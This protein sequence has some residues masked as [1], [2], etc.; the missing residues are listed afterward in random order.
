MLNGHQGAEITKSVL[1]SRRLLGETGVVFALLACENET[2]RVI[3][4]PDIITRGIANES[5]EAFLIE[6]AKKV[7]QGVLKDWQIQNFDLRETIR[8][9]LRR[10]F[11][12]NVG[13]KPVVVPIIIQ[14]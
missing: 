1:K 10:F 2:R 6:E 9:E 13:K 12:S 3:G 14:V 8:I 11:N 4:G 7:V 5:M